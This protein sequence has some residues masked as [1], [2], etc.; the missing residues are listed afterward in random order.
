MNL[1]S[2][3][4][5]RPVLSTVF[6][7]LIVLFGL[8]GFRSLGV[9]EY[10]SIDPPVINVRT[11]F[12][13][14][15]A[16]VVESQITEPIEQSVNGIAGISY[17]ASTSAESVSSITVE[18][19]LGT[20]LEAAA[21]DVRDRVSR[22]MRS[23]PANADPPVV[24]KSDADATPIVSL[25]LQSDTRN[26]MELTDFANNVVKERMQ[27][28]PGVS[29]VRIMGEQK[30]SM[31]L[32]LDAQKMAAYGITPRDV[33]N[34]VNAENVELPSGRVEGYLTELVIRT[35][36][37]MQT[38]EEFNRIIIREKDGRVVRLSDIGRAALLPENERMILR[39]DGLAPMVGVALLPLPGSNHIDIVDEFYERLEMMK[40]ELP[41]D[42]TTNVSLDT[43]QTIRRGIKE[44]EET[45]L[46]SFVLVVLVIFLFLRNI[47]T[48]LI[49]VIAI[50]ISL[51]GAFFIMYLLNYSINILTL[52]AIVLATGLVV[53]DAIVVL[54]NIYHKIES[55]MEPV[56]AGHRGSKEIF[57]AILSTTITLAAVF[58]P[59]IFMSGM[60]G[61]LFREFGM[62]MAGS[63]LI[64]AFVSL[65]LTPMMSARIIRQGKSHG[66]IYRASERMLDSLITSY[67]RGLTA[68]MRRRWMALLIMAGAVLLIF[69]IGSLLNSELA[70]MEDKSRFNVSTTAPE[71][72][73]FEKMDEYMLALS[74]II[75]TLPEKEAFTAFSSPSMFS[76]GVNTG[77]IRVKLSQPDRRQRSQQDIVDALSKTFG[78]MNEARTIVTQEQTLGNIR[79]GGLPVQ[80]VIQAPDF[81]RLREVLP[82]FLDRVADDPVFQ[83]SDVNLKFN[84]P[85][86]DIDIDRDKAR[87]LGV[88]VGD[89]AE[90]LQLYF[91][92]QRYGYFLINDKQYQIIGQAERTGRDEPLDVASLYIRNDRGELIQLS[93]LIRMTERSNPPTLYRYNR[94]VSATVLA[95]TAKGY[96]LGQGLKEM[97]RIAEEELDPSFITSL[98]G[99]SRD[100]AQSTSSMTFA[101]FLT[102]VLVY[103][104]LAA[105]FESY[106]D[107]LTI[108]L[109]VPLALAGAVLSLWLFGQ[110]LNLFSQ[111]GIIM[112]IGIVTKNGILIVEFANQK[113]RAGMG[114]REAVI[115]AATRRLRPILMTSFATILGAL[116]IALAIGASAKSRVPMGITVIGGLLFSLFLTLFVIPALY[117][118]ITSKKAL[119]K[120][121]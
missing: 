119:S 1:S 104:I 59:V 99:P 70:P 75:D 107:P 56:E 15:S 19:D 103:L 73:S 83:V 11:I 90:T 121:S 10:P 23:L 24:T 92:G 36:G 17:I 35:S 71:G 86:L 63:I 21:N 101:F 84:K 31:K 25:T 4:I 18:F 115:E 69:G 96:T 2:L 44:V 28:I 108:M 97:Y 105:Q 41:P 32:L 42:I 82:R 52:L 34:A 61:K 46:I 50:P 27:T 26:L 117:T 91:S 112:L 51:I 49:P 110:T 72:T 40:K 12:T 64:S 74:A 37:R 7:L 13:G 53:D 93:N 30:Y 81:E 80:F 89:I 6:S 57:F 8:I 47:R 102:L 79:S 118:F 94:Y 58:L 39:G 85:E 9:R 111:I 87:I 77:F 67:N 109:T 45:I 20:D 120:T 43:T 14:A 65:T 76:G 29:E 33:K 95:G 22:V 88:S 113:R 68:F 5:N 48:T 3:S 54:E 98:S 38:E 106:R 66:K 62:V 55:G 116:P 60:T 114:V 78:R 16:D 100:F